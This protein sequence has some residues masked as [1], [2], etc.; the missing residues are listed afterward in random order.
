MRD[1]IGFLDS[2]VRD[3][4]AGY[5]NTGFKIRYMIDFIEK[6]HPQ[7]PERDAHVSNARTVLAARVQEES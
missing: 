6:N 1:D 2:L 4:S 7:S 5:F 3:Y